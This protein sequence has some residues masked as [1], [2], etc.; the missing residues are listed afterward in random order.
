MAYNDNYFDSKPFKDI[1]KRYESSVLTGDSIYLEPDEFTH[2]AEYYQ[3][4]GN[5]EKAKEAIDQALRLFPGA[6]APLLLRSR[7]ALITEQDI[8]KA[9]EYAAC[10]DDKS[11]L[12]YYY[13]Y[14]EIMLAD[15]QIEKADEYLESKY[16]DI[17]EEDKEDYVLDVANLY[18][19]YGYA[20]EMEKWLERSEDRNSTDYLELK[21]RM[22]LSEEDF[23]EAERIYQE[24]TEKEPFSSYYWNQLATT[25]FM[26]G[27]ISDSIQS[28]EF[29]IAI[30]P[31]DTDA[32]V[33][34]A[35]GL[36][37]IHNL[38]GALEYYQRYARLHPQDP[39]GEMFVGTILLN[40]GRS[41]ETIPHFRK[42]IELA[43]GDDARQADMYKQLAFTY[44]NLNEMDKALATI[45]KALEKDELDANEAMVIK[46]YMELQRQNVKQAV[47]FFTAAITN[48]KEN[49]EIVFRIAVSV[50]ENGYHVLCYRL[51]SHLFAMVPDDWEDGYAYMA[52]CCKS[53]GKQEE[54]ELYLKIAC[55][56]NPYE[57]SIAFEDILPEDL[58]EKKYYNYL[59]EK[60]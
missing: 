58:D 49:P 15:N 40:L 43:E 3:E 26:R 45:D 32:I 37:S 11:D 60:K 34:K 56:R 2:I 13:L 10:I 24:L 35:N 14:A 53:L 57:V 12:D 50:F 8:E 39:M 51:L 33:N 29:A 55:D 17:D 30:N 22:V 16:A 4:N 59:I 25:Q 52:Y 47:K 31:N 28:S 48:S 9:K 42:A 46:G 18:A 7:I 54:Y 38:E 5:T 6:L 23:E 1:L 36:F 20:N 44:S 41:E 27:N 21:A 19:D